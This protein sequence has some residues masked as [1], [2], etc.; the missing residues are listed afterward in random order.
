[1]PERVLVVPELE[2]EV[3][4][5]TEQRAQRGR[6]RAERRLLDPQGLPVQRERIVLG[7]P[8]RAAL[9]DE[10]QQD[11][12]V[13]MVGSEC[14]DPLLELPAL[15]LLEPT[16]AVILGHVDRH[17]LDGVGFARS[18]L[19][20]VAGPQACRGRNRCPRGP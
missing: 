10:L 7:A 12:D 2:L 13:R 14:L 20:P 4:E 15:A 3:R 17:G 6:V 11:R 1:V 18:G 5:I 19:D 8:G 16:R 9:R